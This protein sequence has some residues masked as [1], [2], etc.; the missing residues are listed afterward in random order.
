MNWWLVF[1]VFLYFASGFLLVVEVFVPSGGLISLCS[2]LCLAGGVSIFFGVSTTFGW[3]GVGVAVVMI[4]A[5]LVIAYR[6]FPK[7]KF[8]KSV[9]LTPSQRQPGEA[10]ADNESLKKMVGS[11]G[12]VLTPLRPV[13]MCDFDGKR[14]E[15][16]AESG[17]IDKGKQIEVI[18]VQSTQLTVR[19]IEQI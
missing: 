1:A 12:A 5:V 2:L 9:T 8:G 4:P 3:I 19:L 6:I 11:R 18:K 7:T 10:I 13:G 15:C 16:V 14:I 17:Y